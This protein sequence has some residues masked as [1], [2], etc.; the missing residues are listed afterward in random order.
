MNK[1]HQLKN[2]KITIANSYLQKALCEAYDYQRL[3]GVEPSATEVFILR[4]L[5]DDFT[6]A[7][8]TI[9]LMLAEMTLQYE[10][11]QKNNN[12]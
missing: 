8:A 6:H 2:T 7:S 5:S 10:S 12:M 11:N 1:Q 4:Q 9:S 3:V